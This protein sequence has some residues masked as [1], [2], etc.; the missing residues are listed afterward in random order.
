M[1]SD[2]ATKLRRRIV[3]DSDVTHKLK[4]DGRVLSESICRETTEADREY[5]IAFIAALTVEDMGNNE[6][7]PEFPKGSE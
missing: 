3:V 6:P 2:L 7:L 5:L 4:V 1:A